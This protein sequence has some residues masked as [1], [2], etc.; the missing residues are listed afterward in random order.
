MRLACLA[1]ALSATVTMSRM[2]S[3]GF[4]FVFAIAMFATAC[5]DCIETETNTKTKTKPETDKFQIYCEPSQSTGQERL[6]VLGACV[7]CSQYG[8]DAVFPCGHRVVCGRCARGLA[9]CPMCRR[10]GQPCSVL[11]LLEGRLAEGSASASASA[12]A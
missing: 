3:D 8:A 2:A 5:L 9:K 6:R 1:L 4:T 11:L 10:K 7:V 12:S